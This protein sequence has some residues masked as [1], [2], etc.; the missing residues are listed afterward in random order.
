M[1]K[2]RYV[3]GLRAVEQLLSQ[4]AT[5]ILKLYA[6]YQ[7]ANPRLESVIAQANDHGIDVQSANRA[8][9]TQ[10]SGE[11][12]H[13]GVVCRLYTSDAADDAMNV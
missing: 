10:I 11:S 2:S 4:R 8:R 9:L 1:S 6:E 5:E 7:T 3:S 12:R 13:Q